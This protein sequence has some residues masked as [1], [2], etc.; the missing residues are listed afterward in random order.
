MDFFANQ[1]IDENQMSSDFQND[2]ELSIQQDTDHQTSVNWDQLPPDQSSRF[3]P[4]E[5]SID[6]SDLTH[7]SP[8]ESQET[9]LRDDHDEDPIDQ[10]LAHSEEDLPDAD[11]G[12]WSGKI[13]S[14]LQMARRQAVKSFRKFIDCPWKTK[15]YVKAA[16]GLLWIAFLISAGVYLS[17][18]DRRLAFQ[19]TIAGFGWFGKILFIVIFAVSALPFGPYMELEFMIGFLYSIPVAFLIMVIG[20]FLGILLTAVCANTLMRAWFDR[21]ISKNKKLQVVTHAVR[22]NAVALSVLTRFIPIPIGITTGVLAI[23]G[24][25]DWVNAVCGTIAYIPENL[26]IAYSAHQ[27][28]ANN[29]QA[30][31][32]DWIHITFYVGAGVLFVA[33]LVLMAWL[34]NRALEKAQAEIDAAELSRE[35]QE[36]AQQEDVEISSEIN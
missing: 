22:S 14:L 36:E 32:F 5:E 13:R 16:L 35:Q 21:K 2:I 29:Q 28:A 6:V 11:D 10:R 20:T 7:T 19:N 30:D 3:A 1:Q 4:S 25:P 26:L 15:N 18:D 31:R 34:G 12:T 27:L 24:V 9:F 33:T 17:D 8:L 23:G